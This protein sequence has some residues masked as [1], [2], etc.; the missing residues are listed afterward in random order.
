VA[1]RV[2]EGE[3]FM[4]RKLQ[5]P[6]SRINACKVATNQKIREKLRILG[7]MVLLCGNDV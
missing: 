1:P 7:F 4:L 2:A 3:F 5:P 6:L